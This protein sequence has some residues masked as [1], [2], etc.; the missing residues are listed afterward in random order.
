MGWWSYTDYDA[1]EKSGVTWKMIRRILAYARPYRI[2]LML[3]LLTI[4]INTLVQALQP[5]LFRQL[6]DIAL[7]NRD[8]GL[9]DRLALGIITVPLVNAVL[10]IFQG[11]WKVQIS[12]GIIYD[13]RVALFAHL[14]RM[15]L[16]FFT[17]AKTGE[18]MSR[19]NNDVMGAQDAINTTIIMIITN[20]VTVV[21]TLTIMLSVE[22][23]LT[24]IGLIVV[25]VFLIT[26]RW[27]ASHLRNIARE[28]LKINALLNA[29]MNETLNVSGALLVKL[30]GRR[31]TEVARFSDRADH[32][33][34]LGIRQA[35]LS[36]QFWIGLG[37]IGTVGTTIIYWLGGH[38]V[39]QGSFTVGLIVLFAAYLGQLYGPLQSL[40]NAPITFTISMVSF[41]RVFE[42]LDLPIDVDEKPNAIQLTDI[43]GQITF[44]HVTFSYARTSDAPQLSAIKRRGQA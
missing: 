16:R 13:L 20:I 28:N 35:V 30:F 18:L 37:L 43:H 26:A 15:S 32:V 19:L 7:P 22:W 5:Q 27:I 41:E 21:V 8:A 33:R 25:P 34:K 24:L 17:N 11:Y 1:R 40:T 12:E 44:N 29:T 42:V 6:I 9:L 36:S 4:L 39:L 10:S 2:Q 38:L 14:Q 23:R 31:D 3:T